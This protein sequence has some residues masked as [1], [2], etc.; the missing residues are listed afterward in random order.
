MKFNYRTFHLFIIHFKISLFQKL[1]LHVHMVRLSM[2]KSQE[3]IS[4]IPKRSCL[5]PLLFRGEKHHTF[6]RFIRKEF[7]YKPEVFPNESF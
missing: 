2:Y 3:E 5:I 6:E 7:T 4:F 1:I